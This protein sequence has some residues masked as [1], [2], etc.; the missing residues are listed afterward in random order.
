MYP[1]GNVFLTR[2]QPSTR[3]I[4]HGRFSRGVSQN[5][6]PPFKFWV[7]KQK[8][9][10]IKEK[11]T[12]YRFKIRSKREY[13]GQD[14]ITLFWKPTDGAEGNRITQPNNVFQSVDMDVTRVIRPVIKRL[15]RSIPVQPFDMKVEA[16]RVAGRGKTQYHWR[17]GH[18]CRFRCARHLAKALTEY[19]GLTGVSSPAYPG[20]P[21]P[22]YPVS[23]THPVSRQNRGLSHMGQSFTRLPS[24]RLVIKNGNPTRFPGTLT[25]D[26]QSC[27]ALKPARKGRF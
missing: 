21:G 7:A 5:L 15:C 18:G 22:P 2:F 16:C 20:M 23:P 9:L 24:G 25:T 6:V 17:H 4:K 11:L 8:P 27:R 19:S 13:K 12:F 14:R 1:T 10:K 26:M 3:V